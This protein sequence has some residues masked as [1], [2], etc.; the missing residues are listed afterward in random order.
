MASAA[1]IS[2]SPVARPPSTLPRNGPTKKLLRALEAYEKVTSGDW[3]E[4][5]RIAGYRWPDR[6][7]WQL[8]KKHWDLLEE[9]DQRR[10]NAAIMSTR[11]LEERIV[12][13][14]RNPAHRD[15]FK[16]L[17]LLAKIHGK[18]D[19][20]I[21]VQLERGSLASQIDELLVV[22][23][24][25]RALLTPGATAIDVTPSEAAPVATE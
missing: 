14:A 12:N 25:A 18:L 7:A 24:S 8:K 19:P 21:T 2:N 9:A 22:M 4:A 10:L 20:K 3:T 23:T 17:E 5:V 11:E 16:A 13:L 1:A 6:V 15:H